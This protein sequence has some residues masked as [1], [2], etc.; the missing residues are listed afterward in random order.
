MI[1]THKIVTRLQA[2]G[3]TQAKAEAIA[4]TFKEAVKSNVLSKDM[5][6]ELTDLRRE[7]HALSWLFFGFLIAQSILILGATY[8]LLGDLKSDIREIRTRLANIEQR[9]H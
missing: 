6:A 7:L 3:A 5:R 9:L 4:E 1:D 2:A 8:F